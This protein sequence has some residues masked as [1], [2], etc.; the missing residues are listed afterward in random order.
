MPL[1][2]IHDKTPITKLKHP[3]TPRRLF[4]F[5]LRS[6]ASSSAVTRQAGF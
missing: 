1:T 6:R 2:S 4:R 3:N 5:Q